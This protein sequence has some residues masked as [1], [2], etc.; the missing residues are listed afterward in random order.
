MYFFEE[1]LH[2]PEKA[3]PPEPPDFCDNIG[4]SRPPRLAIGAAASE[5]EPAAPGCGLQGGPD[6]ERVIHSTRASLR[7]FAQTGLG[8]S[9]P[10]QVVGTS[11]TPSLICCAKASTRLRMS[12]LSAADIVRRTAS[13][14]ARPIFTTALVATAP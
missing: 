4:P 10:F 2:G 13:G 5:G 11:T 6:A 7:H 12:S 3:A 8:N 1:H 9:E 14:R